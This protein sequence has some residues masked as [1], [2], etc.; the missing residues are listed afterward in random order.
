MSS[1]LT[2]GSGFGKGYD[3]P[4]SVGERVG[5]RL[6][7][8]AKRA[9]QRLLR[10]ALGTIGQC[11]AALHGARQQ[12]PL[13]PT[14][15]HPRRILIIR[16]DLLGDV[17]MT[18][19]TVAALHHAYPAAEIDLAVLPSVAP[20]MRGQPGIARVIA[21]DPNAWAGAS[22]HPAGR[23]KVMATI[24]ELRAAHYD[25][26]VSVCGDVAS[27]LARLT[28]APRRVGFA[29][30]GY[31]H[32][33]TDAVPGRRFT[34]GMHEV[35]YGLRL[36]ER[37]GATPPEAGDSAR[38]PALAVDDAARA[39]VAALLA[40]AGVRPGQPIVAL[41]A[42]SGNGAAK[43]WPLPAWARLA[44]LLLDGE[45]AAVILIGA[46]GDK[47][48]ATEVQRRMRQPARALDLTGQT[49]LPELAALLAACAVVVSGDSGPL[50]VA[51]AVGTRVVAIHGPTDPA[52]SGPVTP[53]A[54]IV[55]R[56]LWCSPC[57]DSRAT[58]TCRFHDPICMKGIGPAEVLAATRAQLR[59]ACDMVQ[60]D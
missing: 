38:L 35:A 6:G 59:A 53:D 9:A 8:V 25:L 50:H 52:E 3:Y 47:P 10:A 39:R 14:T 13:T 44:D 11:D 60:R 5:Q 31:A 7:A 49:T 57:Y 58:A 15:F 26:V 27:I 54:L 2:N 24:R 1:D 18:L 41:H 37:A 30:E 17:V 45:D 20:L 32:L 22:L 19:P 4:P 36:A 43:R 12:A 42:G 46:P 51:E 55:R 56:D 33:F 48:L 16:T 21:C 40:A 34:L 29:G 23:R 28:G